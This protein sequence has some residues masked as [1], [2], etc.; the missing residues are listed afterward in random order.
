MRRSRVIV[1]CLAALGVFAACGVDGV[2]L[3]NKTCPC[4]ADLTCDTAAN[5]CVPPGSI[6]PATPATA[7]PVCAPKSCDDLA[8]ECG[9][10]DDG[11]GGLLDCG[12][13]TVAD[14]TCNADT[15]KCVCQPKNC[16]AQG[17][18]CGEVPSGC[19]EVFKCAAC[20][21][22]QPN[23]GGAGPN[24]CGTAA[25][26]PA[27]CASLGACGSVSDGCGTILD[28]GGC[29]S[30][31]VC[32]GGGVANKCGCA[33]KTCAQAGWQCG[34]GP[35][36]CG[37]TRTCPACSGSNMTCD[38]THLCKCVPLTCQ[39]AGWQCGSGSNGCGGTL[40]CPAC[41]SGYQ[42]EPDHKCEL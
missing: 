35:D 1:V 22:A 3:T 2:N 25:C 13:C 39:T 34:T 19:G 38:A 41:S 31:A 8:V 32:G 10:T 20:P 23:C 18:E 7:A 17:A 27:T 29:T 28:C 30:P 14:T 24:K 16:A 6:K 15:H 9:A 11:C 42:C 12:K 40:T 4:P 5:R 26:V 37:G 36:N 33:V 21:T